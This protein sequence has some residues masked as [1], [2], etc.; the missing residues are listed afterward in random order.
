MG[1]TIMM[2]GQEYKESLRKRNI[3]VYFKGK[4][5]PAKEIPDN[6]YL[7]GHVNSAALTYDL[8]FDPTCEEPND[9]Y[10]SFNGEK[11]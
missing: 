5:I 11:D 2:T 9:G 1:G 6:P 8:A 7:R 4:Q 3:I 10:F